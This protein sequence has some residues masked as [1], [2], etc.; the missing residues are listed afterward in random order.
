ME[1]TER[2]TDKLAKYI[3][4]AAGAGIICAL[5][6]LFRSILAYILIAVV[7]SLIAKPV[8]GLMQKP[9]RL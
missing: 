2:Y 6:W 9:A 1:N 4:I 8:F 7:V 5:C 3:M